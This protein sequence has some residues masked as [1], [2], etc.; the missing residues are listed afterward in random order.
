M[1][2]TKRL[3]IGI[4]TNNGPT[5]SRR[6]ESLTTGADIMKFSED[7]A[8]ESR[9]F[10]VLTKAAE[11]DERSTTTPA[12]SRHDASDEPSLE[13]T[14]A[15]LD[16]LEVYAVVSALT[17]A[18]AI[19]CFDSFTCPGF[20]I[21]WNE[22]RFTELVGDSIFLVAS[23]T[24]IVAGLHTT[25]V[26]SLFTMYGRTAVGMNRDDALEIFFSNTGAQR[27]H[28]FQTFLFS[29]YA[30]LVQVTIMITGKFPPEIRGVVFL[31][32]IISI[33]MVYK[34]TQ[35]VISQASVIYSPPEA[36]PRRRLSG[37]TSSVFR[38]AVSWDNDDSYF[39][40]K[41]C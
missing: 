30:F 24:G 2:F 8:P 15:R 14:T 13:R 20:S 17:S 19:A 11:A 41:S 1:G 31:F 21:L 39:K 22:S 6:K 40:A 38:P 9:P 32:T 27:Y 16:G 34:D 28:G 4:L 29:L 18:T 3:G 5:F 26:F 25:L 37:R 12:E 33:S 23:A 7:A 10:I 36:K 35:A